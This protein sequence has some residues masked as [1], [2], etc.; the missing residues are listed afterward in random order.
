MLRNAG[1]IGPL[2]LC[3][4]IGIRNL[5]YSYILKYHEVGISSES[6]IKTKNMI[7]FASII[8]HIILDVF[9]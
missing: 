9:K 6:N 7:V 5:I 3:E 1:R 4:Y 8:F 2:L